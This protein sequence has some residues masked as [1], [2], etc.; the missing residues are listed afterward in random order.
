MAKLVAALASPILVLY[1]VDIV[2]FVQVSQHFGAVR[3]LNSVEDA[4]ISEGWPKLIPGPCMIQ[5]AE[6]TT[7]WMM[8]LLMDTLRANW[9]VL[10]VVLL[11]GALLAALWV[12]I[13][14]MMSGES[15][16]YMQLEQ[17]EG[18]SEEGAE[19][20][21]EQTDGTPSL[22][23]RAEVAMMAFS[24][25]S[26]M[27]SDVYVAYTYYTDGMYIFSLL[28]TAIWLGS[29]C[30]SFVHRYLSWE[31]CDVETNPGYWVEGLNL[32][33]EL[34]SGWRSFVMYVLQVQP[35]LEAFKAFKRGMTR[36]LREEKV[37]AALCEGAPSS[38]LQIYALL[39]SRPNG[40][41]WILSGSICLSIFTVA[42]GIKK[43]YELCK[44]ED[45][46]ME[47]STLP[48]IALSLFRWCDTFSRIGFWALLGV[49][50]R[51]TDAKRQGLQQPYLPFIMVTEFLM[52][53]LLF[54]SNN[55]GLQMKWNELFKKENF[56]G[57]IASF[58][59]TFWCCYATDLIPQRRF[60]RILLALRTFS[61]LCTLWLFALVASA[62]FG[63]ECVLSRKPA[64]QIICLATLLTFTVTFIL[65]IM[66]ELMLSWCALPL[67]PI[68][69]G[70][71][72]GRLELAARLGLASQI[73][74][75]LDDSDEEARAA[76]LCQAAEAG[77]VSVVQ[78]LADFGVSPGATW[79]GGLTAMHYAA[80]GG[81]VRVMEDLQELG[82]NDLE[83]AAENGATP[84]HG[85]AQ[86]GH[87]EVLHFLESAGCDLD[88]TNHLGL[89]PAY[90]AAENG[91]LEV[92]RFLES[93]GCDL[94]KA[95]H[96]GGT[97]A[98]WAAQNGQLEVLRFLESSGA[99]GLH[100]A[101]S[102]ELRLR[103]DIGKVVQVD[104]QTIAN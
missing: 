65:T 2:D 82:S 80:R 38:L 42:E 15:I 34:P 59:S 70:S 76:A 81:H 63:G 37:L 48:S 73:G 90:L 94:E 26:D 85:A 51:P 69:S 75:F 21:Q 54:K 88:K 4:S 72:G 1:F 39:V 98:H 103:M 11:D 44:P 71:H 100:T 56:L 22:L 7:K 99:T 61:A 29:G 24:W 55:F 46:Q 78:S 27:L 49:C 102:R 86:N 25:L 17:S 52:I 30:L 10:V 19:E 43:A 96:R 83:T 60:S 14:Y 6:A 84:A 67:F 101:S 3:R 31:R 53:A 23:A 87:W 91:H 41:P 45:R 47:P 32:H 57:I 92:L 68:I 104:L 40:N 16:P 95:D 64:V 74:H 5:E 58:L 62:E 77:H 97:P 18:E 79:Q 35:L 66:N 33:G 20:S 9:P 12:L 36:E 89:T 50:L 93:A 28:L 13:K 8:G